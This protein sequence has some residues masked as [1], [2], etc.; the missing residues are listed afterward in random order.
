METERSQIVT[1]FELEMDNNDIL[2]EEN[3]K[4]KEQLSS[5]IKEKESKEKNNQTIVLESSISEDLVQ[6]KVLKEN[7]EKEHLQII[8]EKKDLEEKLIKLSKNF[9]LINEKFKNTILSIAEIHHKECN[10]NS[11]KNEKSMFVNFET[12][13]FVLLVNTDITNICVNITEYMYDAIR[14]TGIPVYKGFIPKTNKFAKLSKDINPSRVFI[15]FD[16][17]YISISMTYFTEI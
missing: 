16:E 2:V 15:C 8:E 6:R 17:Y 10:V 11:S 4:L 14:K 5:L 3:R 13:K 1:N 9:E 12:K 7:Q